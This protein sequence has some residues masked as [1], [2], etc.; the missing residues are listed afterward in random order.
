MTFL[1]P[2]RGCAGTGPGFPPLKWWAMFGRPCGTG[3][4]DGGA[5]SCKTKPISRLR[6]SDWGLRIGDRLAARRWLRGLPPRAR[7]ADGAKRTQFGRSDPVP[8]GKMCKT[9]PIS[10]VPGG[11][12]GSSPRPS[13]LRPRP[14]ARWIVQNKANSPDKRAKRTQFPGSSRSGGGGIRHHRPAAA[15]TPPERSGSNPKVLREVP[16]F[17]ARCGCCRYGVGPGI[18]AV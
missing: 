16:E 12:W 3:G 7:H 15:F 4:D 5:C 6:I 10:A 9:N 2:L 13:T 1:S 18:L 17:E 11:T 14:P 8:E